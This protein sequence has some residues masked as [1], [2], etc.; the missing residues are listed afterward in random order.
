MGRNF[1]SNLRKASYLLKSGAQMSERHFSG[2]L[3]GLMGI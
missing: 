1:H 3:L 2:F